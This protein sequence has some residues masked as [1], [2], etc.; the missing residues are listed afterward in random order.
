CHQSWIVDATQAA[1][2]KHCGELDTNLLSSPFSSTIQIW[3]GTSR[4]ETLGRTL[5]LDGISSELCRDCLHLLPSPCNPRHYASAS[6]GCNRN[7]WMVYSWRFRKKR[8]IGF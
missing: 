4:S 5:P 7:Q 2:G 3:S 6:L 1:L 8:F